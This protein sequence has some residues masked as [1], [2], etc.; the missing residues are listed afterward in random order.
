[1][2]R[3]AL[4]TGAG[5][6]IGRAIA[7]SLSAQGYLLALVGRR[8]QR[9]SETA[10]LC[11]TACEYILADLCDAAAAARV[12]D[13]TVSRLRRVDVLVNNA[14]WSPPAAIGATTPEI[15]RE[16]FALNAVAPCVSIARAWPVFER[17]FRECGTGGV[18][19]N[20]SSLAVLD[21]FDTLY[22]YAGAKAA[23][24][25]FT[26]SAARQG[27]SM[28]VRAFAIAPGAVETELLRSIADER[29][30]PRSRVL[31]PQVIA[32]VALDCIRGARDRDNGGVIWVP[33]P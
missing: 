26:L 15:A 25:S 4:I 12:V 29:V 23:L 31:S 24:H 2:D 30:L 16:V 17:Q 33:S 19:V 28:G 22:A 32:A 11:T 21:P 6:G 1:M 27:A 3:V 13:D 9:L 7:R 5:S 14:G 20:I 10:A 8:E 18:V